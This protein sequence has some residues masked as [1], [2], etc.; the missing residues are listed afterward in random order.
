MLR[1]N[2]FNRHLWRQ[3]SKPTM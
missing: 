3:L 2:I 1:L